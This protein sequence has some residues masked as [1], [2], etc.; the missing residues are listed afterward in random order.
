MPAESAKSRPE[1]DRGRRGTR[2][3]SRLYAKSSSTEGA[4]LDNGRDGGQRGEKECHFFFVMDGL[5]FI[6]LTFFVATNAAHGRL[7]WWQCNLTTQGDPCQGFLPIPCPILCFARLGPTYPDIQLCLVGILTLES[8]LEDE[9][10]LPQPTFV[11]LLRGVVVTQISRSRSCMVHRCRSLAALLFSQ[12]RCA[13]QRL[14]AQLPFVSTTDS[15]TR[16]VAAK[17]SIHCCEK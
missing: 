3:W 13:W 2:G 7:W 16:V 17:K 5:P 4:E 15:S 14:R 6:H 9:V 11:C 10:L 12:H 1:Q 8:K